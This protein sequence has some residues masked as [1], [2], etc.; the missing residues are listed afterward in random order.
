MY[1]LAPS[2]L[3]ADFNRL[4]EQLKEIETAG[5][6]WLHVDVMDGSFVPD[7][8]FGMPVISSIRKES[9]LLFDVHLMIVK[10]ERYIE[11]FRKAG[12]DKIVVHLEACDDVEKTLEQIR[13]TGAKAGISIKPSTPVEAIRKIVDKI[14]SV[15]VMTVEPGFGGQKYIESSTDKIKEMRTLLSDKAPHVELEID[16][17]VHLGNI[18]M[19]IEAGATTFVAGSAVFRG[20]ITKNIN[21]FEEAFR[22]HGK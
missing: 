6:K 13:A 19:V 3:A 5:V 7:I 15:L 9:K 11:E 18:D 16:G 2:M 22:R 14:D 12:A 1:Q 8:S 21:G 10:P 4:G 20:D 17:G